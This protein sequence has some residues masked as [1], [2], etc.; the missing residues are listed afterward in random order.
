MPKKPPRD[1]R[2]DRAIRTVRSAGAVLERLGLARGNGIPP[3]NQLSEALCRR[4]PEGLRRHVMETVEKHGELVILADSA[5][6]AARVRLA[7]AADPAAGDG[8]R[9]TVKVTPR[10]GARR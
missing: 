9:I 6:W 2:R 3:Q 5:N 4:L 8:R 7:L 1:N 10:G